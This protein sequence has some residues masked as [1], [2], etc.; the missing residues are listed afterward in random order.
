MQR[1]TIS[2]DD[3]TATAI[4]DYM[5]Q[6]GYSNRSEAIRDLVRETLVRKPTEIASRDHCCA[7]VS[8]VYD[9]DGRDL[10]TRLDRAQHEHHDL[11]IASMKTSLN[12]RHC[13]EVML[14]KGPNNSVRRFAEATL[15]ERGV[16]FGQINLV[17]I[18]SDNVRHKHDE[19]GLAHDHLV[20]KL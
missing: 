2:L 8:Y 16:V 4:D 7:A 6:R 13:M 17:P 18:R 14:L 5:T 11:I 20:P 3:D 10:A 9:Y 19:H 12:H 1:L 15:V